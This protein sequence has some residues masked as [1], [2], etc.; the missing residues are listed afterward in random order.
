[1]RCRHRTPFGA[2][3]LE[4]GETRFALWAPAAGTVEE[5]K[6]LVRSA[7]ERGLTVR[8]RLGDGS[9]LTLLANLA[10]EPLGGLGRAEG[11][12]LYA[13]GGVAETGGELPG[14]SVAWYLR[15]AG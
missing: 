5:L 14:W 2:E 6:D 12:L 7:R 15:E 10:S 8:W 13:S 3:V 11:D 4:N 1:M 9:L